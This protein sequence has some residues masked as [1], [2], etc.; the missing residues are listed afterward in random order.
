MNAQAFVAWAFFFVYECTLRFCFSP[1][2]LTKLLTEFKFFR[3]LIS[4]N[5]KRINKKG[6]V[7]CAIKGTKL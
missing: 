7:L 5:F 1:F 4:H 6:L 2:G 3:R